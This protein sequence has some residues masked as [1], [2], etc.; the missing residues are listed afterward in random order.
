MGLQR[1]RLKGNIIDEVEA[2]KRR[3]REME[4]GMVS[5]DKHGAVRSAGLLMQVREA[6]PPIPPAGRVLIYAEREDGTLHVRGMDDQGV[7]RDLASWA[8]NGMDVRV[9][10]VTDNGW[11]R[12]YID[13]L[14]TGEMHVVAEEIE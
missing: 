11:W 6:P 7:V 8:Q 3:V 9:R 4:E 13:Q 2:L 5:A 14:V 12:L 10:D 1:Q